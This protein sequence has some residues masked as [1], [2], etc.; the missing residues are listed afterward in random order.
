[1][2]CG[3][4]LHLQTNNWNY[5]LAEN[6]ASLV[7]MHKVC[8]FMYAG[9]EIMVDDAQVP[10]FNLNPPYATAPS[11]SSVNYSRAELVYIVFTAPVVHGNLS[12]A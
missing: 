7:S 4:V 2:R 3:P 10:S 8:D 5:S 9:M 11:L 1:M 12:Y 6:E